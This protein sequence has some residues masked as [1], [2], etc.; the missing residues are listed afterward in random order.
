MKW[1]MD[2]LS[3]RW[4]EPSLYAGSADLL[5]WIRLQGVPVSIRDEAIKAMAERR[6]LH[7]GSMAEKHIDAVAITACFA[8]D[9]G[10]CRK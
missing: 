10:Q 9:M 3:F 1:R 5:N 6:Q 4:F 8:G 2:W 7:L